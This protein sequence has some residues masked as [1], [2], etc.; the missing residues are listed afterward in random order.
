MLDLIASKAKAALLCIISIA[1][2]AACKTYAPSDR[3]LGMSREQVIAALG[4][5]YPLPAE[6]EQ[7]KRLDFPRG[8]FGKHTYSVQFD[9]DGKATAYRQLLIEENFRQITPGMDVSEVIERI[10]MSRDTFG[11]ARKRGYVWN[12][13][14]ITPLCQWFQ[15]EFTAEHKVRSTGYGMP[16]E[17]RPKVIVVH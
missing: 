7:A 15:I 10:G 9:E 2:L 6:L 11:L 14:Y 5:P 12:F 3:M 1:F 16:P 4:A 8:P 13:R 17:C